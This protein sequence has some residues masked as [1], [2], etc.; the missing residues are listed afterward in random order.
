MSR[1]GFQRE[2]MGAV[3]VTLHLERL[4]AERPRDPGERVRREG[5]LGLV[6]RAAS[7]V[8]IAAAVGLFAGSPKV[9]RQR[10]L[11]RRSRIA[12]GLRRKLVSRR[13]MWSRKWMGGNASGPWRDAISV[14]RPRRR[15]GGGRLKNG[16]LIATDQLFLRISSAH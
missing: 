10:G 6:A 14:T 3:E 5:F 2:P 11:R 16:R 13:W 4:S 15:S 12:A 7:A 8:D 9:V 1:G